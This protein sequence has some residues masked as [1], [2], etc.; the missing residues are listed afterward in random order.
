MLSAVAEAVVAN[1]VCC[2]MHGDG[3][4]NT[5][6][7]TAGAAKLPGINLLTVDPLSES[8]SGK[9]K[10]IRANSGTATRCAR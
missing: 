4:Q 1:A 9:A 5:P 6:L 10:Y 2:T 8:V 7:R 3:K